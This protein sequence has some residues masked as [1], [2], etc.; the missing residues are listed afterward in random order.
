MSAKHFIVQHYRKQLFTLQ[1]LKEGPDDPLTLTVLRAAPYPVE[2][3]HPR[4]QTLSSGAF[5]FTLAREMSATTVY[6][7]NVL[8]PMKW[9][10]C[11]PL[12]VKR[13][14][15]S[16]SRPWPCVTLQS[17]SMGELMISFHVHVMKLNCCKTS[18]QGMKN[19]HTGD[20]WALIFLTR[21]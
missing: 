6:S 12:Q 17:A 16:G 10:S 4:R 15:L 7:E 19:S 20:D 8:V 13:E 3:P 21:G 1:P 5:S 18:E 9:N 14:V 2:I 11:F